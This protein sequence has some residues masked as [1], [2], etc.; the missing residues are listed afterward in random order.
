MSATIL[1]G[2][3]RALVGAIA[4]DAIITDPVWPNCPPGLLAGWDE[5]QE[6]LREMLALAHPSVR[7]IVIILRCDSDP[8]F[9]AAIPNRWKFVCAQQLRYTLPAFA[10]R[11]LIGTEL[12]YGFGEPVPSS[13]GRRVIPIFSPWEATPHSKRIVA[14]PCSRSLLHMRWLVN[15]WSEPGETVLDPFCGAGSIPLAAD[16]MQREGIGIEIDPTY[17]ELA[18]LRIVEDRGMFAEREMSDGT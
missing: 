9:L 17:A 13:E 18:R 15:W 11:V 1:T 10:G 12:A 3:A 4:A 8:R 2:D 6:L 16:Q 5:P 7:R 14:H